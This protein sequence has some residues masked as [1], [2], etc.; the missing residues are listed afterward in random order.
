M[1]SAS[2]AVPWNVGVM[3]PRDQQARHLAK[4]LVLDEKALIMRLQ[5]APPTCLQTERNG[6]TRIESGPVIPNW[7]RRKKRSAENVACGAEVRD[8]G[9]G[10][11]PSEPLRFADK[12]DAAQKASRRTRVKRLKILI[13]DDHPLI[14]DGL[15]RLLGDRFEVVGEVGN[16][17][18]LVQQALRLQPDLIVL[19]IEMPVLNGI[20]AAHEIRKGR[21]RTKFVFLSMHASRVYLLRAMEAGASAYVLKSEVSGDLM[22]A[23][24]IVRRGG[25]Y[26]S[27][28]LGSDLIAEVASPMHAPTTTQSALTS[29]QRQIL[30]LIS[31]GKHNK[32]IADVLCVSVRTVEFHRGRLKARLGARTPAALCRFA[33]EEGLAGPTN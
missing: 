12:P 26:F 10:G 18:D 5:H 29:R 24:E 19:D 23:I 32:E 1:R 2:I 16:G 25:A 33:I 7:E 3:V 9:T 28:G 27:P 21:V 15:R 4:L 22:K 11:Q 17:V 20:E 13:S 8:D 6:A 30:Q 14:V 31:E